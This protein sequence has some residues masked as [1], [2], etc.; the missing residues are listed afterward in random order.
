MPAWPKIVSNFQTADVPITLAA[1]TAILTTGPISTP[2]AGA[3]V[4][5]QGVVAVTAGAGTTAVVIR[6]RRGTGVAG[7]IVGE[8]ETDTLAAASLE[9]IPFAMQDPLGDAAGQVY[10][11]TAQQTGGTGNGTATQAMVALTIP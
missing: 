6:V 5:I 2:G 3:V 11:L 4:N 7:A 9:A 10:T 8:L 1:E